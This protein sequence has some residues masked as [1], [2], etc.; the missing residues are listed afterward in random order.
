MSILPIPI[1]EPQIALVTSGALTV[2]WRVSPQLAGIRKGDRLWVRE[3]F[4][5]PRGLNH[6]SPTIAARR[7]ASNGEV[8]YFAADLAP[9]APKTDDWLGKR[10]AARELL[11]AWHRQHLMVGHLEYR[12]LISV[13]E[14]EA[15][16]QGYTN[17]QHFLR[18]WDANLMFGGHDVRVAHNPMVTLIH[19]TRVAAPVDAPVQQVAA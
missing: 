2:L 18:S 19:F 11:K 10:R 4:H 16:E 5:L 14:P 9:D 17:T 1:I 3:P 15:K 6:L 8:P 12:R 7:M 13:T